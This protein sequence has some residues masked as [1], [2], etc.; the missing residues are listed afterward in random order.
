MG[1]GLSGE[2]PWVST[3]PVTVIPDT[4]AGLEELRLG[5]TDLSLIP[6]IP[7]PTG[8]AEGAGWGGRASH[9][10]AAFKLDDIH[11]NFKTKASAANPMTT[12]FVFFSVSPVVTHTRCLWIPYWQ[13]TSS[14]KCLWNP[15]TNTRRCSWS[16]TAVYQ[17]V[18][19]SGHPRSRSQLTLD[20]P[21]RRMSRCSART[22]SDC[23]S[24]SL[25]RVTLLASLSVSLAMS[26]F[27]RAPGPGAVWW[28][29]TCTRRLG[30]A[31]QEKPQPGHTLQCRGP[32]FHASETAIRIR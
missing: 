27:K 28:G 17:V 16:L 1:A 22:V 24:R 10:R 23:P 32:K 15:Q 11:A 13:V 18:T 7:G 21:T 9:S 2:L 30:C 14:Q 8:P 12:V 5:T 19:H 6:T 4:S 31:L 25:L 26:P 3:A 29:V 20:T